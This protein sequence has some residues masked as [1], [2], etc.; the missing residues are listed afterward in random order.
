MILRPPVRITLL[1]T[2][3]SQGVPVIGCQCEVCT[4]DDP[5][6]N[7]LRCSILIEIDDRQLLVDTGP[8]FRQQCLRE[9][10]ADVDAILFTHPHKDHIAGFDELRSIYFRRRSPIPFWAT[11]ATYK[12]LENEFHYFFKGSYP[13][14]PELVHHEFSGD[15]RIDV[16]GFKVQTIPVLHGKMTVHGFRIGKFAYVTDVNHIPEESYQYLEDLDVLILSA[17]RPQP[18]YSHF[19]L[20]EALAEIEKI[21]PKR[22]Y[23]THISHLLGQHAEVEAQLPDGV[24]LAY[25]GLVLKV[26]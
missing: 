12:Q 6:D 25:D 1:G 24:H 17:L 26:D 15:E 22:T 16:M 2:G 3:T 9:G 23:L 7:R 4:S 10:I 20:E 18:H 13:G 19:T 5:R 8:D 21:R 14:R 11:H